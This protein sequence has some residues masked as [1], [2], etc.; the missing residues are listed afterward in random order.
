MGTGGLYRCREFSFDDTGVSFDKIHPYY[1]G[2]RRDIA[3]IAVSG[4]NDGSVAGGFCDRGCGPWDYGV[5][6]AFSTMKL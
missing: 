5:I 3:M 2:E 1:Q 4:W 6:F